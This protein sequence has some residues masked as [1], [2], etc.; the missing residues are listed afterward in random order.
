MAKKSREKV[1]TAI[2]THSAHLATPLKVPIRGRECERDSELLAPTHTNT[3]THANHRRRGSN[4]KKKRQK[5]E[6]KRTKSFGCTLFSAPSLPFSPFSTP[7]GKRKLRWQPKR[8]KK[9]NGEKKEGK[10]RRQRC[11]KC[12]MWRHAV[13]GAYENAFL[14][15]IVVGFSFVVVIALRSQ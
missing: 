12:S 9:E 13:G 5:D 11:S 8:A 7:L 10:K 15:W 1:A 4:N 14:I 3:H 6:R 2:Y